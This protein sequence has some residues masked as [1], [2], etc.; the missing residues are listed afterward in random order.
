MLTQLIVQV[1]SLLRSLGGSI[2]SSVGPV[3][4]I[5][6]LAGGCCYCRCRHRFSAS[7]AVPATSPWRPPSWS[8]S[9][10]SC[11]TARR[12]LLGRPLSRPGRRVG[13]YL[14]R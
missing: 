7:S 8:A 1:L 5:A 10:A 6:M 12:H 2:L 4:V 14:C 11:L 13:R 9:W 3:G